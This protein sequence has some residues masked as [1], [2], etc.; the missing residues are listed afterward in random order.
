MVVV[1][2]SRHD[3]ARRI[4]RREGEVAERQRQR[5]RHVA[6]H[7][8]CRTRHDVFARCHF[9]LCQ[10]HI[11]VGMFVVVAGGVFAVLHVVGVVFHLLGL[12]ACEVAFALLCD[13]VG[14]VAATCFEV[15]LHGFRLVVAALVFKDGRALDF[16]NRV[17]TSDGIN[18][19]GV[20]VHLHFVGGEVNV[21]IFYVGIAVH[22]C[23]ILSDHHERV[24]RHKVDGRFDVDFFPNDASVFGGLLRR[25]GCRTEA[26]GGE[27]VDNH[28]LYAVGGRLI[29]DGV[30]RG[31][32]VGAVG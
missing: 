8:V 30:E 23:R 6:E 20:H 14:D 11:E 18:R 2:E 24:F 10:L 16:A 31:N 7:H 25:V 19:A 3:D 32:V 13:D 22:K 9:R 27:R 5:Q 26:V 15:V 21:L 29:G 1:A 4:F 28:R 12:T 17:G